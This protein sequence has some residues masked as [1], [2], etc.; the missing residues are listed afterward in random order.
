MVVPCCSCACFRWTLHHRQT[1]QGI[2]SG[3]EAYVAVGV[4]RGRGAARCLD[5]TEMSTYDL[6]I[7]E[8]PYPLPPTSLKQ[9]WQIQI[10]PNEGE[11]LAP[12]RNKRAVWRQK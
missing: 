7:P 9:C 1:D 11:R 5:E 12:K 3:N 4:T 8:I 10:Q 6:E 2:G